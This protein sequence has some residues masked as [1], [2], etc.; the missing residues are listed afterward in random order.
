MINPREFLFHHDEHSSEHVSVLRDSEVYNT[1]PTCSDVT[2]H[3]ES[4]SMTYFSLSLSDLAVTLCSRGRRDCVTRFNELED[5]LEKEVQLI[6]FFRRL[7]PV[8]DEKK[9]FYCQKSELYLLHMHVKMQN[10]CEVTDP[11]PLIL[12]FV[13]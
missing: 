12:W 11:D 2:N 9:C 4:E 8:V 5:L 1:R 3:T 7:H 6:I 13:F 10:V